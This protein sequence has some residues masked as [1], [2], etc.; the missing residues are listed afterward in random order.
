MLAVE[1]LK[2]KQN[3]AAIEGVLNAIDKLRREYGDVKERALEQVRQAVEQNPHLRVRT[4]RTAGVPSGRR[5]SSRTS[6]AAE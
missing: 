3:I 1:A 2:D 4:V 5:M 6:F